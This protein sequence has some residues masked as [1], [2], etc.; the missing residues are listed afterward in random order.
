MAFLL[1]KEAEIGYELD[2][3]VRGAVGWREAMKRASVSVKEFG[4]AMEKVGD[5]FKLESG[6]FLT[7]PESVGIQPVKAPEAD[8]VED[9]RT[10][11]LEKLKFE[12]KPPLHEFV[13]P[14]VCDI[15]SGTKKNVLGNCLDCWGK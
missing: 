11:A 3:S 14:H 1:G 5:A 12:N 10:I 8:V 15:C 7:L 4:D 13:Q 6:A 9:A 2:L